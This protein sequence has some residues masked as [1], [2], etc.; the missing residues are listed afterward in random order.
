MEL[1]EVTQTES[2]RVSNHQ[3][4]PK[5]PSSSWKFWLV[6]ASPIIAFGGWWVWN[7]A[8]LLP[9]TDGEYWCSEESRL[10]DM[11]KPGSDLAVYVENGEFVAA[12]PVVSVLPAPGGGS[13]ITYGEYVEGLPYELEPKGRSKL[14]G[15][16]PGGVYRVECSLQNDL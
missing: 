16:V 5:D 9:I 7:E 6:L 8:S 10:L 2:R 11:Y 13:E 1:S 3:S 15:S 12:R 4:P 14:T